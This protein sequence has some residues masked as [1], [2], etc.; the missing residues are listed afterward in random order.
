M[1]IRKRVWETNKGRHEA[2]CV[3]YFDGEGKRRHRTFPRKKD[4]TD[5]AAKARVQI[6]EGTHV[7]DSVSPTV[8]EAADLWLQSVRKNRLEPTTVEQ[9]EQHV[10]LHIVPF[11]GRQKL[12]KITVPFVR[13]FQDR[14][15]GEG[16][17]QAMVKGVVSSL[18]ALLA[19]AQER[20]LIVRNAVREMRGKRRRGAGH[21]RHNGKLKI[22]VDI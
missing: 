8:L 7:A 1:S 10:R 6:G 14:L 18:G 3:D 21:D 11:I 2:W 9:Y 5:W 4:A 15:D 16:R 22:G 20:G 19:D 17:S 13:S 12:S